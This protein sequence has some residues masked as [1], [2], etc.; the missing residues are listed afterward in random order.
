[1][2]GFRTGSKALPESQDRD[3]SRPPPA[4]EVWG[5]VR[6][7]L[8]PSLGNPL[9]HDPSTHRDLARLPESR[10]LEHPQGSA[11]E[12]RG[13]RPFVRVVLRVPLDRS[14]SE[15]SNVSKRLA[16]GER[17]NALAAAFPVNEK[18]GDA[19]IGKPAQSLFV[20]LLAPDVGEFRGR[21]ELAPPDGVRTVEDE[22]G[23]RPAFPHSRL[24][25]RP[26]RC[27]AALRFPGLE[28][29]RDAPAPAEDS[30][31]FLDEAS[32]G[33]PGLGAE[34]FRGE[35]HWCVLGVVTRHRGREKIF[36]RGPF[37]A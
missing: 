30:T 26:V 8:R 28:M 19:P 12:E 6:G 36:T 9:Y 32:E 11:T 37:S 29:K 31:V 1:M 23:V 18:A 16:E 33:R 24:F 34:R 22:S 2:H 27:R 17:G 35:S 21:A 20:G 15:S 5:S 10:L 3:L 4:P 13:G 7:V 14:A 25:H